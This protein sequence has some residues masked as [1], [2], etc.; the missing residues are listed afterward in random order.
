[1]TGQSDKLCIGISNSLKLWIA[2]N[3]LVNHYRRDAE[4]AGLDMQDYGYNTGNVV[5][6]L[7]MSC[8]I[9][10]NMYGHED[11]LYNHEKKN[12]VLYLNDLD[13]LESATAD[14]I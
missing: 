14:T 10:S 11:Q 7:C 2:V 1:M 13:L 3:Q 12:A 4:N 5:F 6:M 8:C 9:L